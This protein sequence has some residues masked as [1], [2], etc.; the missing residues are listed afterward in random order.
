MVLFMLGGGGESLP[1]SCVVHCVAVLFSLSWW[2]TA[3]TFMYSLCGCVVHCVT[4]SLRGCVHSV[5]AA[6]CVAMLFTV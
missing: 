4:C 6:Q 5:T 3:A 1:P 2:G